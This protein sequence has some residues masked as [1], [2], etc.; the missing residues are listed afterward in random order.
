VPGQKLLLGRFPF[1]LTR[2]FQ[3]VLLHNVGN[4]AARDLM[5][6]IGQCVLD[7]SPTPIPV[8]C[9]HPDHQLLDLVFRARTASATLLLPSYFLAISL[10]CQ[11]SSVAG[12]TIVWCRRYTLRPMAVHALQHPLPRF[13]GFSV[14]LLKRSWRRRWD[15]N[16]LLSLQ[17]RKLQ[18][19]NCQRCHNCHTRRRALPTIAHRAHGSPMSLPRFRVTFPRQ[20]RKL[21]MTIK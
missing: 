9:G 18:I 19:P 15:S 10:R 6:R 12:V 4:R 1:P 20:N 16:P 21:K 5:T 13:Y 7:S 11:A 2:R 17:I 14:K 8:L 3:P